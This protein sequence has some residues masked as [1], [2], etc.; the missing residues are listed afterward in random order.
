MVRAFITVGMGFGDEGKGCTV[1]YLCH[2]FDAGLVIRYSGGAQCAHNVVDPNGKKHPFAMFGSGTFQGVPTWLGPQVIVDPIVL[3]KEADGLTDAGFSGQ[4]LA[5]ISMH[6]NCLVST[7][8][9]AYVNRCL[10]SINGHGTCGIGIGETRSY[11]LKY[12]SDAIMAKDLGVNSWNEWHAFFQKI[13]LMRQRYLLTLVGCVSGSSESGMTREGINEAYEKTAAIHGIFGAYCPRMIRN[14]PINFKAYDGKDMKSVVF[15]GAQGILLDENCGFHPHTTWSDVTPRFASEMCANSKE[16]LNFEIDGITTIGVTRCYTT[17]HG[18]GPLP[19]EKYPLDIKDDGNPKHE[20]Q[21][22][23]RVGCLDLQLLAYSVGI[24]RGIRKLDYL[25]L[26]CMDQIG[27]TIP[28]CFGRTPL[29]SDSPVHAFRKMWKPHRSELDVRELT[30]ES[31]FSTIGTIA[32]V[33]IMGYGP[34][35]E[36]R[37]CRI[38]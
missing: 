15:E 10:S 9:H 36:D 28:V 7:P 17:R 6:P 32:P 13:E 23:L 31:L 19:T 25:A 16:L 26:N 29:N 12:G 33:G 22:D 3:R 30:G 8:L 5:L 4:P 37:E 21:G 34:K 14:F 24:A 35:A 20:W 1:E 18:A 27:S 38:T 2:H 11:W